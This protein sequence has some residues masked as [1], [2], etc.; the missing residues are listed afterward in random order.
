M[1]EPRKCGSLIM[2]SVAIIITIWRLNNCR[3][4]KEMESIEVEVRYERCRALI[5]VIANSP[6]AEADREA[7]IDVLAENFAKLGEVIGISRMI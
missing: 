5:N 6:V 2:L 4:V 1:R 3:K 7:L